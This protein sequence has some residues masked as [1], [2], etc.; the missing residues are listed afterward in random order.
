VGIAALIL[1]AFAGYW[2]AFGEYL[3]F[4]GLF[5]YA[6]N[7][8]TP[9]GAFQYVYPG[10]R[11]IVLGEVVRAILTALGCLAGAVWIV[12][13]CARGKERGGLGDPLLLFACLQIPLILLVPLF[14]RYFLFLLPA[15]LALAVDN[16]PIPMRRLLWCV[17]LLAVLGAAS[18]CLMHDWLSWNS[19]RWE[20]GR[21]GVRVD[22]IDPLDIEGGFEWDGWHSLRGGSAHRTDTAVHL[23][24]PATYQWFPQ[25]RGRYA[26]SFS[27][28]ARSDLPSS[29]TKV[30]D[31]E[32]YTLWLLPGEHRF[33]LL[34]EKSGDRR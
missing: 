23:M 8:L 26:L 7:L 33:Y 9:Y 10:E 18:V 12:S 3:P 1:L 21:R 19:A 28:S 30:V 11:P 15:A 4:G 2:R 25:I 31:S 29:A 27:P 20:L 6:S 14:D 17:G 24:L 5:P 13:A 22:H 16:R 32:P 34:E